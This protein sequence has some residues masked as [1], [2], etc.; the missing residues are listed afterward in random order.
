MV[1]SDL[2]K[3]DPSKQL[4]GKTAQFF[5]ECFTKLARSVKEDDHSKKEV[6][7]DSLEPANLSTTRTYRA[8]VMKRV[9]AIFLIL[10]ISFAGR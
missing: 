3:G 8:K 5:H 6:F 10:L 4:E 1:L 7:L 2:T 9:I